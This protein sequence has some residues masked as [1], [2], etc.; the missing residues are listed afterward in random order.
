MHPTANFK[1]NKSVIFEKFKT[2]EQACHVSLGIF[3]MFYNFCS[4]M[5]AIY[6]MSGYIIIFSSQVQ[7]SCLFTLLLSLETPS[8]DPLNIGELVREE[9]PLK[10]IDFCYHDESEMVTVLDCISLC[11]MV[12]AY[13]ADS[14]RSHQMLVRRILQYL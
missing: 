2:I 8:P 7:S 12:V 9:Q 4:G 3:H 5:F 6:F 1:A 11:V 10:A 14:Q 13:A